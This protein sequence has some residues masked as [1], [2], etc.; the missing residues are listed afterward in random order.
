MSL[1]V[2]ISFFRAA[3]PGPVIAEGWVERAGGR[4]TFA[5]GL[6]RTPDGEII[7]KGTSTLSMKPIKR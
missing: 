3:N 6:L 2:K 5:E 7:A 1:E 4:I